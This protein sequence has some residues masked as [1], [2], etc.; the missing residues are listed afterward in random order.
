MLSGGQRAVLETAWGGVGERP[1]RGACVSP[2]AGVGSQAALLLSASAPLQLQRL[3][4]SA[5][6]RHSVSGTGGRSRPS[7]AGQ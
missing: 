4:S 2:D 7:Q 3:Q 6:A 1:Q 5:A